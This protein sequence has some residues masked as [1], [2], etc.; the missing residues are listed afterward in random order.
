MNNDFENRLLDKK[1]WS[2]AYESVY[3]KP[4]IPAK[5][6]MNALGYA[7]EADVD[8]VLLLVDDTAFGGAKEGM[9]VTSKAIYCHEMMV[10]IKSILLRDIEEIGM[11]KKSQVLVNGNAFFKGY[12][13]DHLALLTITTR[14]NSVL[15]DL[16]T[17]GN[18]D[19]RPVNNQAANTPSHSAGYYYLN[20]IR[21]D[22]YFTA[23]QKI[24]N[25]NK[26]SSVASFFLGDANEDR[27]ISKITE[28]CTKTIHK[29]VFEFRKLF[30]EEKNCAKL[31][32]DLATIDVE[33][34]TAARLIQHLSQHNPPDAV[35]TALMN[36]GIPEALFMKPGRNE[37]I[38]Y[39]VIGSYHDDE[40]P[41]FIFSAR[42]F[43]LNKEQQFVDDIKP[44]FYHLIDAETEENNEFECF[45]SD[46]EE[47]F[48]VFNQKVER[49]AK[50]FVT[51]TLNVL[52]RR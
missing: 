24:G 11:G 43:V 33:C 4:N 3:I 30:V 40:E 18:E 32:N 45:C 35:I 52:Y 29:A 23:I 16:K 44:F 12:I 48:F 1:E 36:T 49:L 34:Y 22:D 8:H 47:Q 46:F 7:P 17:N 41:L 50:D 9:L 10:P 6:L 42:L 19:N 26:V 51:D 39:N 31:A 28:A 5:K 38:L 20:F 15:K 21:K 14:I 27:P 13:V 37:K 2:W 25:I